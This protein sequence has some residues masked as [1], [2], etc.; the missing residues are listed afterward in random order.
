MYCVFWEAVSQASLRLRLFSLF[1]SLSLSL[2]LSFSLPLSNIGMTQIYMFGGV[3]ARGQVS[4]L[5]IYDDAVATW[6]YIAPPFVGAMWPMRRVFH[7]AVAFTQ[8]R[9]WVRNA[10]DQ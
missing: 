10:V 3:I 7:S 6:T 4:E 2:P 5:W 1:L 9:V 8:A